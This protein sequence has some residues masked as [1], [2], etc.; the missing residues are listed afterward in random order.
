MTSQPL[1]SGDACVTT[2]LASPQVTASQHDRV[3]HGDTFPTYRRN[4]AHTHAC[5]RQPICQTRVNA[6]HVTPAGARRSPR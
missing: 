5:M 1:G 3:T 4:R 2:L 6:S